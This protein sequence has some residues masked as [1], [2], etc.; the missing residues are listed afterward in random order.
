M[1]RAVRSRSGNKGAAAALLLLALAGCA[2]SAPA[3]PPDTT[4]LNRTRELDP[5]R[6]TPEDLALSCADIADERRDL[7]DDMRYANRRIEVTR[8]RNQVAGYFGNFYGKPYLAARGNNAEKA[9]IAEAYDRQDTLLKLA[10]LKRC[11]PGT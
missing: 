6:F 2:S 4:S 7:A 1:G 9:W 8:D 5:N 11:P 3:L 10:Q